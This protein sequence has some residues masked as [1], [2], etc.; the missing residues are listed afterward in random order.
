MIFIHNDLVKEYFD[1]KKT[2]KI[3]IRG[4]NWLNNYKLKNLQNLKV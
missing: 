4:S 1:T 3:V 2:N